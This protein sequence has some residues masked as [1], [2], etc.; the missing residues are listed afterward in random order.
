MHA[1]LSPERLAFPGQEQFSSALGQCM[2]CGFCTIHCPTFLL[3]RDERDSP[4]GRV[5]FALQILEEGRVPAPEAVRHLDRCLSCLGCSSACPFGVDHRHLWDRA[6]A[7]IAAA[8]VRSTADRIQRRL[9]ATLLTSPELFRLALHLAPAGRLLRDFMPALLARMVHLSPR[10]PPV[11]TARGQTRVF[12]PVGRRRMRVALLPGCVQQVFGG[13]IDAATIRLLTR[14]GCEVVVPAGSGCCGAL[15]LHIGLGKSARRLARRNVAAW[16]RAAAGG[17]DAVVINASGCG[18]VVKDYGTLLADDPRWSE[19]AA[20]METLARDVVELVS[21]LPLEYTKQANGMSVVLHLP[22][23]LQHGQGIAMTPRL[24]LEEAGFDVREAPEAHLC[25]GSAGTYTFLQPELADRLG[26]RKA[27]AL[28]SAG[29]KVIAT[30]NLGC[31]MHIARFS[32]IPVVHT[33][34]LLDWATG[35]EKPDALGPG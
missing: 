10:E 25:C 26:E 34:E 16:E 21:A 18:S 23:S 31:S 7:A 30:G 14:H 20:R 1:D 13:A 33:V 32:R 2:T 6:R 27:Q 15:P 35:G 11:S 28:V 12:P 22:C 17:L 3:V 9:L 19:S 5:R 29:A 4:R 24:L 8:G